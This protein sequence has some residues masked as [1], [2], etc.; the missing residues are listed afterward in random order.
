MLEADQDTDMVVIA[1]IEQHDSA[2]LSARK[3]VLLQVFTARFTSNVG[4]R[5]RI[6]EANMVP[7]RLYTDV[8]RECH[9]LHGQ[10]HKL[11]RMND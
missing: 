3:I 7:H 6:Y 11:R 9:F 10:N 4:S 8:V 5:E 2:P 1:F